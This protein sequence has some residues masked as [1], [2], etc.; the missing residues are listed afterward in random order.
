MNLIRC[1]TWNVTGFLNITKPLLGQL[2]FYHF[3]LSRRK[4]SFIY[5]LL[6]LTM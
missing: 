1:M 6:E 3:L 5:Y 2:I 4:H